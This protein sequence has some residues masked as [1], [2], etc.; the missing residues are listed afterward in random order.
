[1][2][3]L[4]VFRETLKHPAV[5]VLLDPCI[6][7]RFKGDT[8]EERRAAAA[9]ERANRRALRAWRAAGRSL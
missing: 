4:D 2:T 5:K 3:A 8:K 1:M 9:L 7:A 6:V